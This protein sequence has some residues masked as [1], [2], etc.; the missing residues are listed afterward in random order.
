MPWIFMP[1][2]LYS[3][4]HD[5]RVRSPRFKFCCQLPSY[6]T[7]IVAQCLSRIW[8][9]VTSWMAAFQVS[10]SSTISWSLLKFTFI[11]LVMLSNHLNLCYPPFSFAFRLSQHQGLFQW[12][13]FWHQVTKVLE[14]QVQHQSFKWL[15]RVDFLQEWLVWSP[16]SPRTLL[17]HHSWKASILWCSAFFTVQFS[18]PYMTTG[19]TIALTAHNFVGKVTSLLFNMLSRFVTAFLPRSKHLLT[20]W[21]QSPSAV[22]LEPPKNSLSLFPLFLHLFTMKWRDWMPWS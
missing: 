9:F 11:E 21:L 10:L 20:S 17:Q 16:C 12:L 8:F 3:F 18:H 7:F 22:I 13:G 19:E 1:L 14:L 4:S 5:Y 15:F 2:C 6:E